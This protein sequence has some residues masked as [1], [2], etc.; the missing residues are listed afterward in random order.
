[1][2]SK[3]RKILNI[4]LPITIICGSLLSRFKIVF[5]DGT[6]TPTPPPG[7]LP[8]IPDE[9]EYDE[10]EENYSCPPGPPLYYMTKTPSPLWMLKC[11]HCLPENQPFMTPTV[12]Y[13]PSPTDMPGNG[14]SYTHVQDYWKLNGEGDYIYEFEPDV[15]QYEINEYG[16]PRSSWLTQRISVYDTGED[17]DYQFSLDGLYRLD[18]TACS[19]LYCAY[20]R[21]FGMV[22]KNY[23]ADAVEIEVYDSG[24]LV[25][26]WV[27]DNPGQIVSKTFDFGSMCNVV[28]VDV[29]ITINVTVYG[30]SVSNPDVQIW[31]AAYD[32]ICGSFSRQWHEVY[33]QTHVSF[34]EEE[35]TNFVCDTITEAGEEEEDMYGFGYTGIELGGIYC[36]NIGPYEYDIL[37]VEIDI[38]WVAYICVQEVSLGLIEIFGVAIDLDSFC[39]LIAVAWALR[40]LFIS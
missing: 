33:A 28:D 23:D 24:E 27:L 32:F 36:L 19:S 30:S 12:A 39:M 5:A 3:G 40:N 34:S 26:Y 21:S 38:P 13:T 17:A 25:N 31:D 18:V 10:G 9:I 7:Y 1:M 37:G 35:E 16:L 14:D 2:Y 4:L 29:L 11:G 6:A 22:F 15:V 8:D 20:D